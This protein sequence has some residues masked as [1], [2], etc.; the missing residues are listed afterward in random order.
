MSFCTIMVY[1]DYCFLKLNALYHEIVFIVLY[2]LQW[3]IT[4]IVQTKSLSQS[5][6]VHL[7]LLYLT[8]MIMFPGC[9]QTLYSPISYRVS[10]AI[11]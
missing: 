1:N 11:S 2:W 6:S 5:A 4:L 8:L 7:Q 3:V 10:H 9:Q